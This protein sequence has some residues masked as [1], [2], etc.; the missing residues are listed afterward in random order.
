MYDLPAY[1]RMIAD[2]V[3]TGAYARALEQA[4]QP[5]SVVLDIGTGTAI[6]AM[7]AVR[8]GARRV[9]ALE[10]SD[11]IQTARELAEVNG[12]ADRIEF[13]QDMSTNVSLPERA[14]VMVAEIHGVLSL[15]GQHLPSVVD[16]RRRHLAPEGPQ[17]PR[18]ETLWVGLV[19]APASY[20]RAVDV[21]TEHSCGFDVAPLQALAPNQWWR[22]AVPPA[23]F[24]TEPSCWATLD[25][26]TLT[27]PNAHGEARLTVTRTGTAHGLCLW[28]DSELWDGIGFSNGPE[29]PELIFGRALF[30]LTAPVK[31]EA[32]DVVRVELDAWLLE[33]DYFWRWRTTISDGR[34]AR[35][36][37][38]AFDQSTLA[39]VPIS[40]DTL[41]KTQATYVP[42]LSLTG[43]V[44]Q[45]VLNLMGTGSSLGEI[46]EQLVARFPDRFP[47]TNDALRRAAKLSQKYSR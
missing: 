41:R 39:G 33:D 14:D 36:V 4:V 1:G 3:R 42:T 8:F 6:F 13:I 40:T 47:S 38:A 32:G 18:R 20:R 34:D 17:I 37:K 15:Y 22:E 45:F 44:D 9:F 21:W 43:E 35:V 25:Y 19:Q 46:G 16:A 5:G 2:S 24:L 30:A 27:D 7:L 29:A 12:C 26:T 23:Q 28:F 10:A 11:V 31:V